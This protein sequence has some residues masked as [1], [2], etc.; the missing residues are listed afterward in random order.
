MRTAKLIPTAVFTVLAMLGF[1]Q[2][3]A[4]QRPID[5]NAAATRA[6]A[7]EDKPIV[8]SSYLVSL[9]V[10]V[11]DANGRNVSG[12]D[13]SAFTILDEN[14]KQEISYF[15]TDDSPASVAIVFD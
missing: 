14:V 9:S 5:S 1:V 7:H 11:L 15:S 12:L 13:K 10:N 8:L 2:S 6:A 4:A 3:G